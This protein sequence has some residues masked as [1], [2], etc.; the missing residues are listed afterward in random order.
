L[1][2]LAKGKIGEENSNFIGL[3]LVP[4]ILAAAFNRHN[5]IGKVDFPDFYLYV[6]EFQNFATP[7]FAT[8]LSEARKYK[9]DLTVGHQFVAQLDDKIK[10]AIFGNVGTMCTFRI[11]ADDAEYLEHQFGPVFTQ[12]DLINLPNFNAYMRLLVKG[13]PTPPFSMQIDYEKAFAEPRNKERAQRIRE[14]SRQK[15]G[16]AA[17]DIEKFIADR[18]GLNDPPPPPPAP[19]IPAFAKGKLPF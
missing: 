7:D 17:A 9:L 4:R 10:E 6:D 1:I 14:M 5:L 11:G 16:T 8:I 18:S 15:Y 19:P 12:K 13:F 2:D 3:L